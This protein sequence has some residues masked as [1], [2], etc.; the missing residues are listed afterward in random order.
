[1][2]FREL[3]TSAKED[4]SVSISPTEVKNLRGLLNFLQIAIVLHYFASSKMRAVF[5]LLI[6]L[7]SS[8]VT[9][10][11]GVPTV[12]PV[13]L[14]PLEYA[15]DALEPVIDQLTMHYHH[16]KHHVCSSALPSICCACML[17]RC[18]DCA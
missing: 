8:F 5:A 11:C 15:Y 2:I 3:F 16:D 9:I 14:P 18:S 10:G 17:A 12:I 7:F 13:E 4:N 1:M 6:V